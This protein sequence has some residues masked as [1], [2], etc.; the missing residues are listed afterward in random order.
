MTPRVARLGVCARCGRSLVTV[1]TLF[2]RTL[3]TLFE[4]VGRV[5][6]AIET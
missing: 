3:V 2:A 1:V 6:L 4:K 5:E